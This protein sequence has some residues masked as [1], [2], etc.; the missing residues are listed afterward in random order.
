MIY[1]THR[2]NRKDLSTMKVTVKVDKILELLAKE[3]L[4]QLE[5]SKKCGLTENYIS[6]IM[7]QDKNKIVPGPEARN[8]ILRTLSLV[9]G[10]EIR[11]DDIFS[12]KDSLRRNKK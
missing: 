6:M 2:Q 9:V 7:N 12:V 10:I 5:F 1:F 8:K 4:T 11:F 3:N